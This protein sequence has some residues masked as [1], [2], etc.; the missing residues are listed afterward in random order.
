MLWLLAE[1]SRSLWSGGASSSVQWLG[2]ERYLSSEMQD[3]ADPVSTRKIVSDSSSVP[4]RWDRVSRTLGG[5]MLKIEQTYKSALMN[6]F[7]QGVVLNDRG[8]VL[9]D[10]GTLGSASCQNALS[11]ICRGSG[12]PTA[13]ILCRTPTSCVL[14]S[15]L[16][17]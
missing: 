4:M 11:G 5:V 9:T 14:R 1:K 7:L 16:L 2:R 6:K 10:S 8:L 17:L 3:I 12:V 13:Y 15:S